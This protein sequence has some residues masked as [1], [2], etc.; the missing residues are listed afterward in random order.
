MNPASVAT[1]S[2]PQFN[3]GWQSWDVTSLVNSWITGQSSNFGLTIGRSD[4]GTPAVFLVTA[5]IAFP[6]MASPGGFPPGGFPNPF[7][8]ELILNTSAVAATPEPATL[9][10]AGIAALGLIGFRSQRG[11]RLMGTPN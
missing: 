10:L 3:L 9:V 11:R 2:L 5:P 8:P 6:G 4:P 1:Q 7:V